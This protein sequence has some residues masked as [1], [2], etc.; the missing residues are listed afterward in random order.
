MTISSSCGSNSTSNISAW[1]LDWPVCSTRYHSPA[2]FFIVA[3]VMVAITIFTIL[4]NAM[5]VLALWRFRSLRTMSNCLIGNLAISDLLL[6]ITVLPVSTS[7]DL[8]G[9]WLYGRL[10]CTVWLC[11][12]VLYC[13]ASIWGLCTIAFDRYM[14]TVY[15]MWYLDQRSERKAIFCIIFVWILST[16]VSVAPF[17]G[18]Q[19]MIQEFW[20]LN[21]QIN[22]HECVLFDNNSYVV[23]SATSSFLIPTV[24]MCFM[25]IR[26]FTV[27]HSQGQMMEKS[28]CARRNALVEF[29]NATL[30]YRNGEEPTDFA[31]GV[32]DF[33]TDFPTDYNEE[34]CDVTT[35]TLLPSSA[36]RGSS[37]G[38]LDKGEVDA[39]LGERLVNNYGESPEKV[40][41]KSFPS[42][43]GTASVDQLICDKKTLCHL[44]SS[45]VT[46]RQLRSNSLAVPCD[47]GRYSAR[48]YRRNSNFLSQDHRH[49]RRRP[50]SLHSSLSLPR[51]ASQTD[52]TGDVTEVL[53]GDVGSPLDK[54]VDEVLSDNTNICHHGAT[55]DEVSIYVSRDDDVINKETFKDVSAKEP[56]EEVSDKVKVMETFYVPDADSGDSEI[57]GY[58]VTGYD[59]IRKGR[60]SIAAVLPRPTLHAVFK[61]R[62]R[63]GFS[64]AMSIRTRFQIR[65]QSATKR[66]LLIMASFCVCWMPFVVM[67]ITRAVC[68]TCFVDHHLQ[69]AV[70]WLGYANSCLNPVL[71]TLFNDDFR[72]AFKD[73]AGIGGKSDRRRGRF[74]Y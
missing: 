38:C 1:A 5:V 25:Y 67:Y 26:I 56:S 54:S 14:A 21:G 72:Q 34:E 63:K 31:D 40:S 61:T 32:T 71:Y 44:R 46:R 37:G 52:V 57:T 60:K 2:A 58:D 30:D 23:Y 36:D 35:T 55:T 45:P 28:V 6:A 42:Q 51:S 9:Y 49:H 47:R 20:T 62:R 53:N 29:H 13:T 39:E 15:P 7:H 65:E 18:W 70:I 19:H 16:L 59:V 8:L 68:S 41:V 73:L 33:P 17:I 50:C 3:I 10:W 66:M 64:M 43:G 12:D 24:L 22:R 4:G 74:R 69:A 48:R 11:I 27:L